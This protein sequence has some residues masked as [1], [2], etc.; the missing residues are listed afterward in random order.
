MCYISNNTDIVFVNL[1]AQEEA[2]LPFPLLAGTKGELA[3]LALAYLVPVS[4]LY[5]I[6]K[7]GP[8]IVI[9]LNF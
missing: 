9:Y 4:V 7:V 2:H 8:V 1:Q 6:A 5:S 3:W